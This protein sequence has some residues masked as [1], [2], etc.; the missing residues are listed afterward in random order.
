MASICRTHSGRLASSLTTTAARRGQYRGKWGSRSTAC[1]G[2]TIWPHRSQSLV[3]CA[4]LLLL[5]PPAPASSSAACTFCSAGRGR[6][7]KT[8]HAIQLT[9]GSVFLASRRATKA[10]SLSATCGTAEPACSAPADSTAP[11]ILGVRQP[12]QEYRGN[13]GQHLPDRSCSLDV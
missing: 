8:G 4:S 13:V 2:N 5:S 7:R 1:L 12:H 3:D 11:T 6:R 9:S 10:V